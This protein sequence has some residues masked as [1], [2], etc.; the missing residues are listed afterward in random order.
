MVYEELRKLAGTK[1]AQEKPGHTLRATALVPEAS[2]RLV[3]TEKAWHWDS[4]Q[5]FFSAAAE[6]MRRI[7]V[8]KTRRKGRQKHG[9]SARRLDLDENQWI[10]IVTPERLLAGD[11]ALDSL[12][13]VL[14]RRPGH[15][16]YFS[17]SVVLGFLSV[18]SKV[19]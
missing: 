9:G 11:E 8:E 13:R 12:D 6:A 17:V 15:R 5:H 2:I 1:L 3:D 14:I 10:S 19:R 16:R 7:L 18:G 4:R